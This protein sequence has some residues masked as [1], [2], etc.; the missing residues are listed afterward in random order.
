MTEE[1]FTF[2]ALSRLRVLVLVS[3]DVGLGAVNASARGLRHGVS[4][5]DRWL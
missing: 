1:R 4:P 5:R 3:C 2:T